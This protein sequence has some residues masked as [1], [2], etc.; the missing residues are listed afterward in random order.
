MV[1]FNLSPLGCLFIGSLSEPKT[2]TF[3]SYDTAGLPLKRIVHKQ[4]PHFIQR[5]SKTNTY[6]VVLSKPREVL[7]LEMPT[8]RS[9]PVFDSKFELYLYNPKTWEPV[10]S[11]KDFQVENDDNMIN[12][13]VL[14]VKEV[15]LSL[16]LKTGGT[17]RKCYI[18]VGTGTNQ[19]ENIACFG[20]ILMF[21]VFEKPCFQYSE[22]TYRLKCTYTRNERGPVTAC[23]SVKGLLCLCIGPKILLFKWNGEQLIGCAFFDAKIYCTQCVVLKSFMMISDVYQSISVLYWEEETSQ[24]IFLGR[25]GNQLEVLTTNFIIN[26]TKLSFLLTD[27][28]G[29][30][31][32]LEYCPQA[33]GSRGGRKLL[34]RGDF[35]TGR[36]FHSSQ[37]L[38]CRDVEYSEGDGP[39]TR[40]FNFLAGADGSLVNV[41]PISETVY[42]RLHTLNSQMVYYVRHYG[43]LN[44]REFRAYKSYNDMRLASNKKNIVDGDMLWV[45]L[46]LDSNTQIRLARAIGTSPDVIINNLI[47][48]EKMMRIF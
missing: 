7:G 14:C 20:R 3:D 30:L 42:R 28:A 12:E 16:P 22:S 26:G 21:E 47:Q 46:Q 1:Y 36:H 27:M 9:L 2:N 6:L 44:P 31:Q 23:N 18:A 39:Q 13:H 37:L 34:A 15:W 11:F 19:G 35:H 38:R 17:I 4:T 29:N 43:G 45:Y 5:H 8:P 40:Y 48:I 41:C 32:M 25:D 24:I 10:D 33:M